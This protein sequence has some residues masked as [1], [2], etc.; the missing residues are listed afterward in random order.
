MPELATP[1]WVMGLTTLHDE[2]TAGRGSPA[3]T[4]REA[5]LVQ[6]AWWRAQDTR[7]PFHVIATMSVGR[8]SRTRRAGLPR[9]GAAWVRTAGDVARRLANNQ[10][11]GPGRRLGSNA[12]DKDQDVESGRGADGFEGKQ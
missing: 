9:A 8:S 3:V 10:R 4:D 12:Y 7:R 11:V 5:V 1:V 6:R 2:A